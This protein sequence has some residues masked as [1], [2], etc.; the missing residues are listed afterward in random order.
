MSELKVLI[1]DNLAAEAKTALEKLGIEAHDRA[2]IE[3][4]DLKDV[5]AEFDGLIVRSRTKPDAALIKA[6]PK[7]RAIGRAG[8]GVDNIDLEAAKA[9]GVAVVNTPASTSQAVAE[10]TMALMLGVLRHL[11]QADSRMKSGEWPKK[12]LGGTELAGKHLGIVGIGNIGTLVA[13]RAVA[14]GMHILAFDP[15]LDN[16]I[17]EERGAK[18]MS[19]K[20]LYKMA[21]VI[22]FHLPLTEET[23][24]MVNAAAFKQM[25]LGVYILHTARGGVIDEAA[26]LAALNSGG[27]A[28]AGLDVFASEP[29]GATDL[30]THP[31]VLATPHIAAQTAEAQ[32][33]AA[34]DV[35]EE[36]ANV[37][38]DKP[39]RWR[40]A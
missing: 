32:L 28:G 8:V 29:P 19:L 26:L 25:K 14:F 3:A 9:A 18:A 5:I 34:I 23:R 7:L 4:D 15:Y 11:G 21:D 37:L 39:L 6:A 24:D 2:G 38:L 31:K 16:K 12:E 1:A 17:I 13:E 10:H 22:S 30:V 35:A 20:E 40:V 27:V 33:R 36:V